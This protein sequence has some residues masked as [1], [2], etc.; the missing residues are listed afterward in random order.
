M[1]YSTVA[2]QKRR[3]LRR[4]LSEAGIHDPFELL[5]EALTRC[6]RLQDEIRTLKTHG[7]AS[8]RKRQE[9]NHPHGS[10]RYRHCC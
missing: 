9:S 1:P 5:A 6:E 8:P 7:P 10:A 3:A 4:E 2:N